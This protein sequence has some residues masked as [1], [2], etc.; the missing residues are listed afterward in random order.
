MSVNCESEKKTYMQNT[1][2]EFTTYKFRTNH[3]YRYH[4]QLFLQLN[5]VLLCFCSHPN[6]FHLFFLIA[7]YQNEIKF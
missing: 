6:V 2:L 1:Q 5:T 4:H 3:I 7:K